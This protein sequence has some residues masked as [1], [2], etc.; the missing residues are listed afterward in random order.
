MWITYQLHA[1]HDKQT[2]INGA[3]NFAL[4]YII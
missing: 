1:G 3:G 4:A 2:Y